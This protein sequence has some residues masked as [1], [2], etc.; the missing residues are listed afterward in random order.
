MSYAWGLYDIARSVPSSTCNVI[1]ASGHRKQ[2]GD[3]NLRML[4]PPCRDTIE[5]VLMNRMRSQESFN[6]HSNLS[7][8]NSAPFFPFS[9]INNS[10]IRF[11]FSGYMVVASTLYGPQSCKSAKARHL[12]SILARWPAVI[13]LGALVGLPV[14][15]SLCQMSRIRRYDIFSTLMKRSEFSWQ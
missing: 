3:R 9:S 1:R 13:A 4:R 7:V 6:V 10:I 15:C 12:T 5:C 11:N 8:S 2:R 14:P